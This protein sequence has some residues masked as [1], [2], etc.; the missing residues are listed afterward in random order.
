[1]NKINFILKDIEKQ[2][3]SYINTYYPKKFLEHQINTPSYKNT[4]NEKGEHYQLLSY[5]SSIYNNILILDLGTRDGLSA[6]T[7][8]YN[9]QNTVITYDINPEPEEMKN[10]KNIVPNL[11]FKQM[12]I[13]D[14]DISIFKKAKIIFM[15][16][17]PH[18]GLQEDRLIKI[19]EK[20]LWDGIL[21]ADD[22]EWFLP[23]KIWFNNLNKVKY[24]LTKWAHGSGTGIIDFNNNLNII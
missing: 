8:A 2:N 13:F 24:N 19:L 22:I 7:L 21:I 6:L 11:S 10:F 3:I 9:N 16:L 1:M 14:E 4:G 17:D 15:D 5:V 20:I 18:D 12:N 23:M